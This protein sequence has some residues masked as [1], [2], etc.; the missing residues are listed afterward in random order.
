V[1][2]TYIHIYILG[3][4]SVNLICYVYNQNHRFSYGEP[5]TVESSTQAICDLA[6]R[7]GEGDEESMVSLIYVVIPSR[8][9]KK[10]D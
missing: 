7:F 9:C 1:L 2:Y 10:Q 3:S 6:L 4:F 5:M 8:G